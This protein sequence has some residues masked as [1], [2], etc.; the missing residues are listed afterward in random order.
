MEDNFSNKK[1]FDFFHHTRPLTNVTFT[2]V[3]HHYKIL[4]HAHVLHWKTKKYYLYFGIMT[5]IAKF[6]TFEHVLA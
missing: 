1:G 6:V 4:M 2:Y 5:I 3:N